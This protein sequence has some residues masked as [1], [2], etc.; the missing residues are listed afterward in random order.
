MVAA[1]RRG[2][3]A[4]G[5]MVMNARDQEDFED[6]GGGAMVAGIRYTNASRISRRCTW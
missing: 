3:P 4:Y 2:T 5:S 6:S 1:Q